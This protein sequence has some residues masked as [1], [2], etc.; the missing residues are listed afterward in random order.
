MRR[1]KGFTLME[2]LVV[3]AIIALLIALLVP[4]LQ[5][6]RKQARAVVCQTRLRQW[7]TFYTTVITENDGHLPFWD[8]DEPQANYVSEAFYWFWYE[9]SGNQ[10]WLGIVGNRCCPAAAKPANPTGLGS[11]CGGTFLAWGRWGTREWWQ[12]KGYRGSWDHSYGSYGVNFKVNASLSHPFGRRDASSYWRISEIKGR[13]NIP[14]ILDSTWPSTMIYKDRL[15]PPKSDAILTDINRNHPSCINRHN[16]SVN[17]LFLD[18]SVRK[19]GL[20]ELWTLKWHREFNTAG[21]WTKAGGV[22][23]EDWPEWM[24]NFKDY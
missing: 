18:W 14:F 13:N 22:K 11:T 20:K 23:P 12:E 4:A 2:L 1:T 9:Q 15:S 19:V 7:G 8:P 10:N 17:A 24:R 16:G 3:I 21:P 6:A 5:R